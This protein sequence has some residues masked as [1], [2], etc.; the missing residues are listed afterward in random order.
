MSPR[1]LTKVCWLCSLLGCMTVVSS[2]TAL[3][4]KEPARRKRHTAAQELALRLLRKRAAQPEWW[5]ALAPHWQSLPLAGRV[6]AKES[7]RQEHLAPLQ[8]A[9]LV[10]L[11]AQG[12]CR[13][14]KQEAGS[15]L[16][17]AVQELALTRE[18][19]HRRGM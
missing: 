14:L 12:G 2:A 9:E 13:L 1:G 18:A 8:D 6:Y 17:L 7:W 11:T 15:P 5:D 3:R 10:R 4:S 16:V 19:V